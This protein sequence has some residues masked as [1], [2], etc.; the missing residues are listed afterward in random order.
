MRFGFAN[1]G[2]LLDHT[3]EVCQTPLDAAFAQY[4]ANE[5]QFSG[6]HAMPKPLQNGGVPI[7]VSGTVNK[8][9]MRRLATFGC[10]WIPWGPDA[11]DITSGIESM[12]KAVSAYGRDPDE[13][14]V[15]G[16]LPITRN[17]DGIDL[18]QQCLMFQNWSQLE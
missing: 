10:G 17:D 18:M 11:I 8:L 16:T 2:R 5:L 12:R 14:Q 7:W 3:L 9:S 13:I 4:S 1:R 6:I 15:I